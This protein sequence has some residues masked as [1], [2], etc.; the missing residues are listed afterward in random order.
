MKENREEGYS[1][2]E[3]HHIVEAAIN[4]TLLMEKVNEKSDKDPFSWFQNVA[5]VLSII[6]TLAGACIYIVIDYG[7]QITILQEQ[8]MVVKDN[9]KICESF[10]TLLNNNVQNKQ[11]ILDGMNKKISALETDISQIQYE[12]K[13]LRK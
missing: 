7:K 5:S 3:V 10:N 4:R 6:L 8:L 2:T 12:I 13:G 9:N 1:E 11:I